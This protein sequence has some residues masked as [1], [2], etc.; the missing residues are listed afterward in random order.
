MLDRKFIV[1]N[2]ELVQTN[3]KNRGLTVDVARFIELEAERKTRQ[4]EVEEINRQARLFKTEK[5]K[6]ELV[7]KILTHLSL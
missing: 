6:N 7:V 3:C 5:Q 1:E 2:A 4:A